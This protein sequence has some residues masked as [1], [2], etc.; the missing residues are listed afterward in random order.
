MSPD[1]DEAPDDDR[2]WADT[3]VMGVGLHWDD[4]EVGQ[5]GQRL[6][7]CPGQPHPVQGR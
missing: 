6:R 1:D 5:P 7:G 2:G 3:P 4:V